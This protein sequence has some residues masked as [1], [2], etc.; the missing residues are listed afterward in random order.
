MTESVR[1]AAMGRLGV[2]T[3]GEREEY[4]LMQTAARFLGEQGLAVE[5]NREWEDPNAPLD[6]R[7][8]VNGVPWAFELTQLRQ[9]PRN[10]HRKVGNPNE[11]NSS[12]QQLARLSEPFPQVPGGPAV[13]QR[14]LNK[15]IEHGRKEHKTKTLDGAKYCLLIH[16]QQ[17][18]S[19]PDWEEIVWPDLGD[20]DA[21]MIYHESMIP[22]ARIWQVIPPD[23]FGMVLDC[24]TIMDLENTSAALQDQSPDLKLQKELLEH[25]HQLNLSEEE[26][27]EALREVRTGG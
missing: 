22:P 8:S 14:N 23:A 19:A 5:L 9:D 6:Y 1:I 10:Y 21:L 17:F 3:E 25:L 13:L 27:L 15:A 20:F 4:A 18:L 7:G 12:E 2:M 24:G 16:N 26:V 11:S